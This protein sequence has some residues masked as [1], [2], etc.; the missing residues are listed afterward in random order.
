MQALGYVGVFGGSALLSLSL[1]PLAMRFA[2]RR[3]IVDEPGPNKSHTSPVPYLG[4]VAIVASF[5]LAVSIAAVARGSRNGLAE[6]LVVLA[7][8]LLVAGVGLMDDVRPFSPVLRLAIETAVASGLWL[9]D[10]RIMMFGS[11]LLGFIITLVW[12]VG[13]MNAQNFIDGADGLSAGVAAIA[14]GWFLVIAGTSGQFL[15]AALSAALAGCAVGFL[16][17]NFQP[18]RIYMGDSGA[19]FLGFMLAYLGIKIRPTGPDAT[20]F[21]VPILVLAVPIFEA[22]FVSIN[23]ILHQRSP[24]RGGLDYTVNRLVKVG[25][26]VPVAVGL[27]YGVGFGV[28]WVAVVVN[29]IDTG[30]SVL[31]AGFVFAYALL[32]GILL[33]FVPVYTTSR[34][35]HFAWQ[36]VA[37]PDGTDLSSGRAP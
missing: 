10:V 9:A 29:E 27:V 36:E 37:E 13:L 12:V 8:G 22:T 15:V 11:D 26:P 23:R 17:H 28:G 5:V 18:A 6:I 3:R 1:T 2:L 14:A 32:G 35:R 20:T 24:L 31:L 30:P 25:L 7:L 21:L 19:L 34:S 33:S 4:G 16:R